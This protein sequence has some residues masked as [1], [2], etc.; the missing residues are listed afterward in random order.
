MKC[1]IYPAFYAIL[2]LILSLIVNAGYSEYKGKMMSKTD[3]DSLNKL[4]SLVNSYLYSNLPL[5]K[6][7]AK[8][9]LQL[10]LSR[11][12]ENGAA[13]AYILLGLTY[14]RV[15]TDSSLLYFDKAYRIARKYDD[16]EVLAHGF[17]CQASL[18][19][20]AY[21]FKTVVILLDSSLRYAQE[22]NDYKVIADV[23]NLL[24]NVRQTLK[25]PINARKLYLNSFQI[26]R[27]NRLDRQCGIALVNLAL[28]SDAKE[29]TISKLLA[30]IQYFNNSNGCDEEIS[31]TYINIGNNQ[32]D[33]DS[34]LFFLKKGLEISVKCNIPLSEI[35]AYNN[36]T[37]C[38]LNK[39]DLMNAEICIRDK[40]IPIALSI[41]NED[42]LATL[43][44]TYTDVLLK[45]EDFKNATAYARKALNSRIEADRQQAADQVRLLAS[46]L[47]LKNKELL[48]KNREAQLF[49]ERSKVQ[50]FRLWFFIVV[51]LLMIAIASVLWINHQGRMKLQKE[52]FHSAKR[53]I[54]LDEYEKNA[55]ARDLHDLTG[56]MQVALLHCFDNIEMSDKA[57]FDNVK[58]KINEVTSS[59]RRISHRLNSKMVGKSGINGLITELCEDIEN[60]TDLKISLEVDLFSPLGEKNASF[61]IFRIIQEMLNNAAKYVI[62][63]Q[64]SLHL[65]VDKK[66]IL[67]SYLDTGPGFDTRAS[68]AGMGLINI[69][70]RV[71]LLGGEAILKSIPS[72]G[73]SW[74][75]SFPNKSNELIFES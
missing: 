6:A 2:T 51:L 41:K 69:R 54:E 16:D 13:R 61:H 32:S 39:N 12:S 71:K 25:D 37:Y 33:P 75:I 60:I 49:S 45:K 30:A 26:A 18:Y 47:D 66:R 59:T 8:Q 38:Y 72:K 21:D 20:N 43:Y 3:L 11:Q 23:C 74:D 57:I 31:N 58:A 73:T 29:E 44:D 55:V 63:G 36:I 46:L 50:E 35:A 40:A 52:Q 42:W 19:F 56:Q 48:L 67:I 64:I 24:G 22:I 34:A 27:A 10:S 7:F 9:A 65:I 70:E 53:I 62:H 68:V 14:L 4:D 5:S 15:N 28:L 17:Y 1:D